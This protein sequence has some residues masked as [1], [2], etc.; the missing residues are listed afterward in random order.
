M[1][2]NYV[3]PA[4]Q[5]VRLDAEGIICQSDRRSGSLNDLDGEAW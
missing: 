5:I 2:T 3:A 4:I 1:K